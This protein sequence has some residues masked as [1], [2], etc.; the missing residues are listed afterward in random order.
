[1]R[2]SKTLKGRIWNFAGCKCYLSDRSALHQ[3][4]RLMLVSLT[5]QTSSQSTVSFDSS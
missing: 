4:A 2:F 5:L 3:I 1:M